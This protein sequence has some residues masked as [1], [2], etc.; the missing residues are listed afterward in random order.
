MEAIVI[1]GVAVVEGRVCGD[2]RSA[3]GVVQNWSL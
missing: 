3:M 2:H 1:G